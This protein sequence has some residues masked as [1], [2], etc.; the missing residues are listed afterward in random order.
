MIEHEAE[1][2]DKNNIVTIKYKDLEFE[3]DVLGDVIFLPENIIE[4][5]PVDNIE[6]YPLN[7]FL[8]VLVGR[9]EMS[10]KIYN[11]NV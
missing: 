8:K 7:L 5:I 2:I 4:L 6:T 9:W 10:K 3:I 1:L 11:I